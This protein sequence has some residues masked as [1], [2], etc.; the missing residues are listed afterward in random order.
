M[1]PGTLP[2]RLRRR[3]DRAQRIWLL[4]NL[5]VI[6]I[7][8]GRPYELALLKRSSH[9]VTKAMVTPVRAAPAY[10]VVTEHLRRA[11]QLGRLMPGERLPAERQLADQLGVSRT[12]LRQAIRV[13]E[14]EGIVESRRGAAGGLFVLPQRYGERQVKAMMAERFAQIEELHQFRVI[15]E[16]AAARAAA[17]NRTD[18][19]IVR[20][21]VALSTMSA[22]IAQ[23]DATKV[24]DHVAHFLAADSD[25]H[26]GIAAATGNSYLAQA[27]EE[28]RAA[29]LI[30]IGAV[31]IR[32]DPT[33]NDGHQELFDAIVAQEPD[34]A[35]ESMAGHL[36]GAHEGIKRQIQSELKAQAAAEKKALGRP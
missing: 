7:D 19:D 28:I 6:V 25:F 5:I 9:A 13:L 4:V 35:A 17:L 2:R 22:I 24:P 36:N 32:L 26:T 23:P 11:L 12:T 20:L 33:T 10:E 15:I 14:L 21:R 16:T 34:R 3:V 27:V 1:E 29:R 18:K 31:F 8:S 30:P